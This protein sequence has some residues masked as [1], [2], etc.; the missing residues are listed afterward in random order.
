MS[1]PTGGHW[2]ASATRS[3]GL[4]GSAPLSRAGRSKPI[5]EQIQVP[6]QDPTSTRCKIRSRSARLVLS[7]LLLPV[8]AHAGAAQLFGLP[9]VREPL[10][11]TEA[12]PFRAAFIAPNM[13]LA[14]WDVQPGH[15]LYKEK[16]K[17]QI[18][19]AQASIA[20]VCWPAAKE[21]DDPFFG[22][23]EVFQEPVEVRLVLDQAPSRGVVLLAQYQGCAADAG[24]CYP[25]A[26]I[27]VALAPSSSTEVED[28]VSSCS[29]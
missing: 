19:A 2:Q 15:Y 7:F 16:L 3:K 8:L 9:Q 1:K 27:E 21:K 28:R 12:F 10:S 26:Q 20:Q 25:P 29:S 24:I 11:V 18:D 22:R 23:L 4:A 14:R 6:A 17:F 5:Q 13:I